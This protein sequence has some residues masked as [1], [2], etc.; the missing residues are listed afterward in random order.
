MGVAQELCVHAC[1][2]V[3]VCVCVSDGFTAVVWH[4]WSAVEQDAHV[5]GKMSLI[6][7]I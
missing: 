3:S 1:V 5:K 6:G 7:A 4:R 2:C